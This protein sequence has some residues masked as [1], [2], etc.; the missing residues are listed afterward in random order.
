MERKNWALV[1]RHR[2]YYTQHE[3][4]GSRVTERGKKLER[5]QDKWVKVRRE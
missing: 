5:N 1:G 2:I 3:N 4:Q